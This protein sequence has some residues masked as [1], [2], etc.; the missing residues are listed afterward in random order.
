MFPRWKS[1]ARQHRS[2]H[3]CSH[4]QLAA[5]DR[6]HAVPL[7]LTIFRFSLDSP[8]FQLD[9]HHYAAKAFWSK[10][11]ALPENIYLLNLK[12]PPDQRDADPHGNVLLYSPTHG[13]MVT[14]L[15]EVEEAFHENGCTHWTYTPPIPPNARNH[16]R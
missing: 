8:S 13:W 6:C 14:S 3:D 2:S 1:T 16:L 10:P 12:H 7:P 15:D 9:R 11:P 4:H 5:T